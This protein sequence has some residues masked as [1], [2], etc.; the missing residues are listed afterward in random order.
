MSVPSSPSPEA[1]LAGAIAELVRAEVAGQVA[2]AL[3]GRSAD[4]Y[5]SV[6]RAAEIASV[7]DDTIRRWIRE[8]RLEPLGA[9]RHLRVRHAELDRLL[10]DGGRRTRR[11]EESP[12]ASA[13]RYLA[14]LGK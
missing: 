1:A 3:A 5:L 8:R 9:G 4:E 12:E 14:R 6:R 2:A 10:A 7:A 11:T 13:R